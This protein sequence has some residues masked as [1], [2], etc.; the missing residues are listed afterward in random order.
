MPMELF[1]PSYTFEVLFLLY[2]YSMFIM[3]QQTPFF[4]MDMP[5]K[6]L[7]LQ[8]YKIKNCMRNVDPPIWSPS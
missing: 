1:K 5:Q 8:R 7:G 3:Y 6:D 2:I 4:T